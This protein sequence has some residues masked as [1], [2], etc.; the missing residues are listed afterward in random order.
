MRKSTY[1]SRMKSYMVL[2]IIVGAFLTMWTGYMWLQNNHNTMPI[3]EAVILE[4]IDSDE[5]MDFEPVELM[6]ISDY[7]FDETE[8]DEVEE[9]VEY[10]DDEFDGK[11]VIATATEIITMQTVDGVKHFTNHLIG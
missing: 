11:I 4:Y 2:T 1:E 10:D 9:L 7:D 3:Q 8:E 5:I 6:S